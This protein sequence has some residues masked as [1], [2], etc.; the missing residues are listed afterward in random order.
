MFGNPCF[1]PKT[2]D[3]EPNLFPNFFREIFTKSEKMVFSKK[4]LNF[5]NQ[6]IPKLPKIKNSE[7]SVFC[8]ALLKLNLDQNYVQ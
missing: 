6:I 8:R 7:I 5:G 3:Y 4:F 2:P 1:D